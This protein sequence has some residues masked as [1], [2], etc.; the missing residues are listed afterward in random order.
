MLT[1]MPILVKDSNHPNTVQYACDKIFRKGLIPLLPN[2]S[3]SRSDGAR[4]TVPIEFE[5]PTFNS[6]Q[7]DD[8]GDNWIP[9]PSTELHERASWDRHAILLSTIG[10]NQQSL[11]V[12]EHYTD[13]YFTPNF[14]LKEN[15][16]SMISPFLAKRAL[17]SL[18]IPSQTLSESPYLDTALF[19]YDDRSIGP[20]ERL[21]SAHEGSISFYSRRSGRRLFSISSQQTGDSPEETDS[22]SKRMVQWIFH[23][24]FP[25]ALSLEHSRV[26]SSLC[27]IHYYS[28]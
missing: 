22:K 21:R 20:S 2:P 24:R 23:P 27:N 15:S 14:S 4:S 3:E 12:F 10:N 16:F 5:G 11:E 28:Q 26:R 13:R 25:L 19:R 9:S 18:P 1:E 8:S 17:Q 7:M 6:A